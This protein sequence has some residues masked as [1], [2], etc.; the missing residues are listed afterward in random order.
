[1]RNVYII[2]DNIK[3]FD[4]LK[5]YLPADLNVFTYLN[6]SF[7]AA[8]IEEERNVPDI[9]FMDIEL[10]AESGIEWA[11]KINSIL[12]MCQMIFISAFDSYY[13]D[14][15]DADHIFF[16]KKPFTKET[17]DKAVSRAKEKL[18]K[19]SDEIFR[20]STNRISKSVYMR[21]I[22]FFEKNRR[23]V[24][25][26]TNDGLVDEYYDSLD[27]IQKSLSDNF[28]RCHNSYVVNLKYVKEFTPSEFRLYSGISIPISRSY[29]K[30]VKGKFA[31]FITGN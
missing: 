6:C 4:E 24:K 20:Y 30:E 25:I 1:M 17:V 16:L 11:K 2:D 13:L 12:P 3:V 22:L 8:D 19:E 23:K 14:V 18:E 5:K 31:A 9:I 29:A 21:D 7:A 26:Y 27:E 28:I 15:Y 10:G